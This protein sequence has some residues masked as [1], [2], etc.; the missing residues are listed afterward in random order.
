MDGESR[1]G[2]ALASPFDRLH[3]AAE[4]RI[5]RAIR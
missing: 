4:G 2:G 1:R 5:V 3:S